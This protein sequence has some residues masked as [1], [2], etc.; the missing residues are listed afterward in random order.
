MGGCPNPFGTTQLSPDEYVPS[1][2]SCFFNTI[3]KS[4]IFEFDVPMFPTVPDGSKL[5]VRYNNRRWVLTSPVWLVPSQCRFPTSG[6]V[7]DNG[8]NITSS[9]PGNTEFFS[10][11]LV[12]P[13]AWTDFP[14]TLVP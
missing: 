6:F 14:L 5:F 11:D 1:L 13:S 9:G 4:A 10:T 7:P 8:P 3:I 2:V 12:V